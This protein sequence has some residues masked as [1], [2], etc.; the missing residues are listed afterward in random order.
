MLENFVP[1]AK[2]LQ[3]SLVEQRFYLD[4]ELKPCTKEEHFIVGFIDRIDINDEITIVDYKS[5][6]RDSVDTKRVEDIIEIKDLQL[7]LYALWAK[8]KYGKKVNASLLTFNT[9][10]EELDYVEF[11]NLKECDQ[12]EYSRNKPQFAC[13]NEEYE[14]A[15]KDRIFEVKENIEQGRFDI[16]EEA[17]CTWCDFKKICEQQIVLEDK[18]GESSKGK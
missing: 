17:D 3:N 4:K 7:G 13:Y 14:Q 18:N 6:K 11:A 1:Y 2:T 15:L 16:N 8:Q 12:P 5:S 10:N 9:G